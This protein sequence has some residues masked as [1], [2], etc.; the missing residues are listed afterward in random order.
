M[1]LRILLSIVALIDSIIERVRPANVKLLIITNKRYTI[2]IVT[3]FIARESRFYK[4]LS[5]IDDKSE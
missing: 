4:L 3:C 2:I 1:I 5:V